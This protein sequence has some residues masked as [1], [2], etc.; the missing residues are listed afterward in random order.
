MTRFLLVCLGGAIGTAARYLTA[1]WVP[2][3]L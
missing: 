3:L 1:I 2:T